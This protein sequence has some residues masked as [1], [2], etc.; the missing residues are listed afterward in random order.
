M[1]PAPSTPAPV[2]SAKNIVE[3]AQ[4]T[5]SLSTLVD[6]VIAAELFDTLSGDGPFTVF[7]P[8]NDAFAALPEGTLEDL[9]LPENKETLT[10]ILK[11]HVVSGTVLST[12]L[13]ES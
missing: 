4:A 12:D 11:Y 3:L 9:L 10:S 7:A 2:A 8:T 13:T 6:A 5:G 1:P